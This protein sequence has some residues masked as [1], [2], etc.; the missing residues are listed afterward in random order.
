MLSP[1]RPVFSSVI[2]TRLCHV[3]AAHPRTRSDCAAYALVGRY[4]AGAGAVGTPA[5]ARL[6]VKPVAA[7]AVAPTSSCL[8]EG[9]GR[10]RE[11]VLAMGEAPIGGLVP[12]PAVVR[13]A[14]GWCGYLI[15]VVARPSKK[16]RWK[17]R[18]TSSSG[19]TTTVA[20]AS[21]RPY[22]VEFWPV[23]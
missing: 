19:S 14:A 8:R 21:N 11:E 2:A 22:W 6:A 4:A 9:L 20:P 10:M 13:P 1:G 5:E 3:S 18:K 15:P 12:V 7:T 17:T 16:R 23:E